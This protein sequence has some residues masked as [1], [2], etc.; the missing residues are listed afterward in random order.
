M[1]R[2]REKGF[3][4][5]DEGQRPRFSLPGVR[6]FGAEDATADEA[7]AFGAVGAGMK[8]R[9]MIEHHRRLFPAAD[10]AML[11]RKWDEPRSEAL[12]DHL[13]EVAE[14]LGIDNLEGIG[15]RGTTDRTRIVTLVTRASKGRTHKSWLPYSVLDSLPAVKK[16]VER[17]ATVAEARKRGLVITNEGGSSS[18]EVAELREQNADL[19]ARLENVEA[20]QAA[21]DESDGDDDKASKPLSVAEI[22]THIEEASDDEREHVKAAFREAE[23][24]SS[25][26]RQGVLDATEPAESSGE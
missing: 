12:V 23:E 22:R 25:K 16:L 8:M 9:R 20:A 15:V 10:R 5:E 1:A 26:P 24:A 13:P 7:A 6:R 2:E 18:E 19:L 3:E 21:G 11:R 4:D 17:A 14:A